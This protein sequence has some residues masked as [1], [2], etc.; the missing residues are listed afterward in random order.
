M[1]SVSQLQKA[2]KDLRLV[3]IAETLP[4]LLRQAEQTVWTYLIR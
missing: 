3:E 1:D 2:F 4:Q